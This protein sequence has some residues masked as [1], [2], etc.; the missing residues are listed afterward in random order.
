MLLREVASFRPTFIL[1]SEP[2]FS[3]YIIYYF[4]HILHII[5]IICYILFSSIESTG[6]GLDGSGLMIRKLHLVDVLSCF[7]RC[8]E[9]LC[10]RS[11]K[12]WAV[13]FQ[14]QKSC[15]DDR[16]NSTAALSNV[17]PSTSTWQRGTSKPW[18]NTQIWR[19][20]ISFNTSMTSHSSVQLMQ[21][22]N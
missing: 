16:V 2:L 19:L 1:A 20:K 9:P 10:V 6:I 18:Q 8:L 12:T 11:R 13:W 17:H 15:R 14:L 3:S 22:E 21:T 5:L 7:S 4:H